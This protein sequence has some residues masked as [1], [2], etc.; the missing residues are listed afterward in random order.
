MVRLGRSVRG[1]NPRGETN[2]AEVTQLAE[3]AGLDSVQCEFESHLRHHF[4]AT[5]KRGKHLEHCDECVD[6]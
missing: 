5:V 2:L 1:S 6:S 4:C 3:V